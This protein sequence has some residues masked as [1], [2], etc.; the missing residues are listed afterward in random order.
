MEGTVIRQGL[1]R[2]TAL[3]MKFTVP[4]IILG[5]QSGPEL[6]NT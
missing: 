2:M 6:E 4:Q 5:R 1:D 3:G